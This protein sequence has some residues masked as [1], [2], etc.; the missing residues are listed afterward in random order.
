MDGV[1]AFDIGTREG[2]IHA[3]K[4][5]PTYG[6]NRLGKSLV[7]ADSLLERENTVGHVIE[8]KVEQN[9][10]S[11]SWLGTR[12]AGERCKQLGSK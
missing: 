12:G 11:S 5:W 1:K 7:N 2:G 8:R 4:P 6:R 3:L 9:C 10:T